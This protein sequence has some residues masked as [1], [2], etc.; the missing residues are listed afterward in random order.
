MTEA[1]G[2]RLKE[3]RNRA[4][5]SSR[6]VAER[7]NM[8]ASTYQKYE[9]RYRRPHLPLHLVAKLVR[10]LGPEGI[11]ADEI[12][13]LAE[14]NQVEAFHEAWAARS[15]ARAEPVSAGAAA[16]EPAWRPSTAGRRRYDRWTPLAVKLAHGGETHACVVRDISPAGA[17]VLAEAA[18]KLREA[19]DVLLEL[20]NRGAVPARVA[21]AEGNE[22]G[23]VFVDGA[24][25][26]REMAAW[27][28]PLR[29]AM[30]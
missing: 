17:C 22:I 19:A 1:I 8:P 2:K 28:E 27:L 7:V 18:H 16:S 25:T 20:G 13:E 4:G 10:A 12:W 26:E 6:A 29:Q 30:H 11:S 14:P 3:L 24:D 21:R 9:D 15:D 5:L 23:L